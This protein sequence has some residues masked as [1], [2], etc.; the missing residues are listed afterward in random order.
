MTFE[1]LLYTGLT[2]CN[3]TQI[4][5]ER[6]VVNWLF[7]IIWMHIYIYIGVEVILS[8]TK[9]M[10]ASMQILKMHSHYN[11]LLDKRRRSLSLQFAFIY[12]L[13]GRNSIRYR[14]H[15]ASICQAVITRIKW[16]RQIGKNL[17]S[18]MH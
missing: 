1:C 18:T 13:Q 17:R 12:H 4:S 8:V 11:I 2:D 3:S 15:T 16:S 5:S 14:L 7:Y 9:L 6:D 10:I